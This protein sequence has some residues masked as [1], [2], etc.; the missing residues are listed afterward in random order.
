MLVLIFSS[1]LVSVEPV[2]NYYTL[3]SS[4]MSASGTCGGSGSNIFMVSDI[5]DSAFLIG[6]PD[7]NEIAIGEV[8]ALRI[9]MISFSVC[10]KNI[11]TLLL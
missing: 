3:G 5:F 9:F 11:P 10:S 4:S 2:K 7:S 1:T 8:D 6:S